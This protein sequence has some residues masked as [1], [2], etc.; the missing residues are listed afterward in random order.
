MRTPSAK[1]KDFAISQSARARMQYDSTPDESHEILATDLHKQPQEL[2][3]EHEDPTFPV[4]FAM[5]HTNTSVTMWNSWSLE[6][7]EPMSMMS[8][9]GLARV[10]DDEIFNHNFNHNFI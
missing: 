8:D 3:D 6:F 7:M 9:D 5:L 2:E 10:F 4:D 1:M